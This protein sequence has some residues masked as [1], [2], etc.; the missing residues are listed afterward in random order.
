MKN[1]STTIRHTASRTWNPIGFK[2]Q[3]QF[4]ENEIDYFTV[5][6]IK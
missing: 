4:R 2:Q 3:Q 6:R 5:E 1:Y